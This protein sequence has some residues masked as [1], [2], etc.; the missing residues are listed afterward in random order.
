MNAEKMSTAN[1]VLI[2]QGSASLEEVC[3]R[4]GYTPKIASTK[5]SRIRQSH[6][7]VKKF[8][9][10]P[11]SSLDIPPPEIARGLLA[12]ADADKAEVADRRVSVVPIVQPAPAAHEILCP[13]CQTGF[14]A[15]TKAGD[16][17]PAPGCEGVLATDPS[18][19]W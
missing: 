10:G 4:T 17:C 15:P 1:F 11:T 3:S 14:D 2:W 12:V 13:A 16:S 8:S 19:G 6:P 18:W 7:E 9:R 5:A